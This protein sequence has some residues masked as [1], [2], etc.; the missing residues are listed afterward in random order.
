MMVRCKTPIPQ[1]GEMIESLTAHH[2][3]IFDPLMDRT[4]R[5]FAVPKPSFTPKQLHKNYISVQQ[6]NTTLH[7]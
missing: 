1:L 6:N 4:H 3:N 2:V 7:V 5:A